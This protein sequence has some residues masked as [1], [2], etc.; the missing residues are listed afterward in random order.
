MYRLALI[1]FVNER[2]KYLGIIAALSFTA[3]MMAQ[4]PAIFFGIL[5]RTTAVITELPLVDLWV[6]D[7]KVENVDDPKPLPDTQLYLVKGVSGVAWAVPFYRGS[8]RARLSDGNFVVCQ[9]IGIDDA[10]LIGGR[11]PAYRL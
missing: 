2:G 1:M 3:F 10:T 11:S 6:M 9:L 8:I 4:Q 7:P 5:S